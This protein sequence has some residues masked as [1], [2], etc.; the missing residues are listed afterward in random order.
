MTTPPGG[1]VG[2]L[3]I[4]GDRDVTVKFAVR[5]GGVTVSVAV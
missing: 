1:S 4:A 5:G 2:S 3:R